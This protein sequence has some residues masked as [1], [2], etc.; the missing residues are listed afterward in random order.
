MTLCFH[1]HK[2]PK[3]QELRLPVL[4]QPAGKA[5]VLEVGLGELF[6]R[7]KHEEIRAGWEQADCKSQLWFAPCSSPLTNDPFHCH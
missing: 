5:S 6:A 2:A 4:V 1:E 3:T 7:S